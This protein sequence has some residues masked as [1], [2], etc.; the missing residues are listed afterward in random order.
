M[1]CCMPARISA[2]GLL[3]KTREEAL[4]DLGDDSTV[5]VADRRPG[6]PGPGFARVATPTAET[7]EAAA[8]LAAAE[9]RVI[10]ATVLAGIELPLARSG[11]RLVRD[12]LGLLP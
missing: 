11:I 3:R 5:V 8:R 1:G 9:Y 4:A 7:L 12:R 6:P 2:V 10:P